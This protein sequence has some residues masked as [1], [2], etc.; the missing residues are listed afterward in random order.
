MNLR[1]VNLSV[2]KLKCY[3]VIKDVCDGN[4]SRRRAEVEL[5]VTARTISRYIKGYRDNGKDFFV[6]GNAGRSSIFAISEEVKSLVIDLFENPDLPTFG[7]NFSIITEHLNQV[8]SIDISES[9]VRNIFKNANILPPKP[10][11]SSK[12]RLR[13]LLRNNSSIDVS[14]SSARA[15]M[16]ED[17]VDYDPHPLIPKKKYAGE[18]IQIDAS[19]HFWFYGDV[20]AHCHV[21]VDNST[22]L[23]VGLYFDY[24]ET[25]C[26]YYNVLKQILSDY[27]I[28]YEIRSDRRTVFDYQRIVEKGTIPNSFIQFKYA[29]NELGIRLSP[30]SSPQ[31]K[32]QVERLNGTL[33]DRLTYF[34]KLHNVTSIEQ[35]NVMIEECKRYINDNFAIPFKDSISCFDNQVSDEKINLILSLKAKRVVSNGNYISLEKKKYFPINGNGEFV[36]LAPKTEVMTIKTLDGDL[37]LSV[38][39]GL[40]M[41][42]YGLKE[43]PYHIDCSREFDFKESEFYTNKA[44]LPPKPSHSLRISAFNRFLLDNESYFD[45]SISFREMMYSST[46]YY[47]ANLN[48]PYEFSN[49]E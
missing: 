33:Q 24:Q 8:L 19:S 43:I 6:H 47:A 40:D 5:Q 38:E 16:V 11:K 18:L 25:L 22:G 45:S 15:S 35:A 34:L 41:A 36:F 21:A 7:A 3:G 1:K 9:S 31:H 26:A 4:K 12:K 30:T 23:V 28:P 39:N 46:N 17:L 29:C 10:W 27:G 37:Y 14:E 2:K 49:F 32:G 42:I 13:K 44:T 20:Y 48:I